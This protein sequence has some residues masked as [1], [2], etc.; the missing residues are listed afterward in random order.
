MAITKVEFYNGATKIGENTTEPFN[1]FVWTNAPIGNQQITAKLFIDGI[2]ADT[3]SAVYVNV[4]SQSIT[5]D[6]DLQLVL[7]YADNNSITKPTGVTLVALNDLIVNLK[8]IGFWQLQDKFTN[9]ALNDLGL[10]DFSLID[11]KR[12]EKYNM[13]GGVT[14]DEY[15][16]IGAKT[17]ADSYIDTL[18]PLEI[19]K[20]KGTD[21]GVGF[22]LN[23]DVTSSAH[24]VRLI[25]GLTATGTLSISVYF[26]DTSTRINSNATVG[27]LSFTGTGLK[28]VNRTGNN[29][30]AYNKE[31]KT[32]TTVTT[33][34]TTP[35]GNLILM[36]KT[37]TAISA[38]Y[39]GA[40][41]T[42]TI[43]QSFRTAYNNYLVAIGL[44][45][46]A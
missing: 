40:Y 18:H 27:S 39:L 25:E 21:A 31:V 14:Y 43:T 42:E 7:D 5:V 34:N 1:Q 15:G 41:A 28:A 10:V 9:A 20:Y 30:E 29:V 36:K 37:P 24:G 8:S 22:V 3:S 19:A 4:V 13:V 11:Y 35:A 44:N 17:P 26:E 12:L 16:W 38:F 6:P 45:P 32:T 33:N 23:K 46:I 2:L